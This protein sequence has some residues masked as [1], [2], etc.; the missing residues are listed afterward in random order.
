MKV[1]KHPSFK[2]FPYSEQK[3]ESLFRQQEQITELS[4]AGMA[5]TQTENFYSSYNDPSLS[6]E[7]Q[8]NDMNKQ[9]ISNLECKIAQNYKMGDDD[10][11][12][13]DPEDHAKMGREKKEWTPED[14]AKML[15]RERSYSITKE[16]K[17]QQKH[18]A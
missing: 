3:I 6:K 4:E 8:P 1:A 15:G 16:K 9:A 14:H 5:T 7:L 2:G 10:E 17:K 13:M 18:A 12:G 11:E